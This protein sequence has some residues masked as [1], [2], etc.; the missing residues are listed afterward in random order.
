MNE[1]IPDDFELWQPSSPF[2]AHMADLG[3]LFRNSTGNILALRVQDAHTNMHNTA[4]GGMLATLAD[5]ALGFYVAKEVQ[6]SVVTVQMSLDYM[7]AV[8]PGDWLEAHVQIEKK[9][10]RLIYASCLMKVGLKVMFKASA[11]FATRPAD[12]PMSDG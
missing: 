5:S 10:R 6:A 12:R 3:S 2:M 4:H 11:V 8:K 1:P 7:N 9:G